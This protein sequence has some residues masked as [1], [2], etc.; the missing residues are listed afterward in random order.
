ME[1]LC[2]IEEYPDK[3]KCEKIKT[4]TPAAT[5]CVYNEEI[6]LCEIVEFCEIEQSPTKDKCKEIPTSTP[7]KT[8]CVYEKDGEGDE[9]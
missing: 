8:I 2:T 9:A 6:R 7:S 3:E 5:K 4:S 1:E